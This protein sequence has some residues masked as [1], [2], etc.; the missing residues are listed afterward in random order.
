MDDDLEPPDTGRDCPWKCK[1]S[2]RACLCRKT[3]LEIA[4]QTRYR[5]R[6]DRGR[7]VVK[8]LETGQI[9]ILPDRR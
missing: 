7:A 1:P 4:R 9:T 3:T 5:V 8:N 6:R 2:S